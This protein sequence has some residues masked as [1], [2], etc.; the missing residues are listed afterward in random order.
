MSRIFATSSWRAGAKRAATAAR[1]R[2]HRARTRASRCA[3]RSTATRA[4]DRP[5]RQREPLADVETRSP[6]R[7]RGRR[8]SCAPSSARKLDERQRVAAQVRDAEQRRRAMR[9]VR[10]GG[11]VN[12]FRPRARTAARTASRPARNVRKV[13]VAA[14]RCRGL[15]THRRLFSSSP[16][17]AIS[18]VA[19]ARSSA[20]LDCS[21]AAVAAL[22]AQPRSPP[23]RPRRLGARP[24]PPRAVAAKISA[25][26]PTMRLVRRAHLVD[27]ADQL[28]ER[29]G[30]R[31]GC[32]RPRSRPRRRS[33]RGRSSDTAICSSTPRTVSLARSTLA[34]LRAPSHGCRSTRWRNRGPSRPLARPPPSR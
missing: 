25:A 13:R 32:C 19:A 16:S 30:R 31:G 10:D 9:H 6:S 3:S 21:V 15:I 26:R 18:S 7:R 2:A 12:D 29:D 11:N 1:L 20:A 24:S 23:P 8:S 34:T 27:L 17:E 22:R 28:L 33:A 14:A 4:V 5:D